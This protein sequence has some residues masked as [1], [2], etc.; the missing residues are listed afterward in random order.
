MA[1]AGAP[2][3]GPVNRP[4][5]RPVSTDTLRRLNTARVLRSLRDEGPASRALVAQRT[6]LAKATVGTI[7][8]DLQRL[9][10]VDESAARPVGRTSGRPAAA[11]RPGRPVTL[12]GAGIVGLGVEVNVGYLVATALD[13]AGRTVLSR[14]VPTEPGR[15]LES[16]RELTSQSCTQLVGQGAHVVGL[17]VAVPGLVA[18]DRGVVVDA[19]NLRWADLDL[20]HEIEQALPRSGAGRCRVRVDND[21]NCSATAEVTHG[22]ARGVDHVLFLTGTV[23]LGAG[24][25]VQGRVQRGST[26]F[27]GEVGHLPV[28][29]GD[30]RCACGRRGCWET[31][32]GLPAMLRATGVRLPDADH[33]PMADPMAA[34]TEVARRARTDATVRAAVREVGAS[35]GTGVVTIAGLL[36]PAMVVL[37]GYFV[38]LGPLIV[39]VVER[40][41][42]HGLLGA[43]A[44]RCEVA[45]STLGLG[46][47]STGAASEVLTDVFDG[48]VGLR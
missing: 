30:R 35:L 27:A 32:V 17:D 18:R 37:G 40:A 28:G 34:A 47:A 7:V 31:T 29:G 4:V 22:A 44:R 42:R 10:A 5:S 1:D 43:G 45:L 21:A 33:H 46:A 16:L 41:L 13:L 38:P 26:G 12:D 39:P 23:G 3:G 14:R 25:V 36:D 15:E 48:V 20:V 2:V 9:R 8:A 24:F 11:G 6:G 19:P